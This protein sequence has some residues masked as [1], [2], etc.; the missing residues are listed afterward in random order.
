MTNEIPEDAVEVVAKAIHRYD[1]REGIA[2]TYAPNK[3]HRAEARA[4]LEVAVP[5]MLLGVE[6]R[7]QLAT[8]ASWAAGYRAG[9]ID[10]KHEPAE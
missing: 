3:H 2:S 1:V 10:A 8:D 7:I 4:M 5:Y 6:R 9:K